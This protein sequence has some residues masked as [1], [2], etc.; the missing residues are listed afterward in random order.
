[1]DQ[2]FITRQFIVLA[3][4]LRKDVRKALSTLHNDFQQY[5]RAIRDAPKREQQD[6]KPEL[7]PLV[8]Q[9]ELHVPENIERDRQTHENRQHRLQIWVVIG[10]WA[11]FAA[12]SIY[13]GVAYLQWREMIGATDAA[14][15]A[16]D[17]SRRNRVQAERSLKATIDQFHLD[18]RA[19]LGVDS[20]S[21]LPK[22]N[23]DFVI[24]VVV[25]NTGKTPAMKVSFLI[26]YRAL[27]KS[28]RLAFKHGSV[29]AE[30]SNAMLPPNS[31]YHANPPIPADKVKQ[32]D[33]DLIKK[34]DVTIYVYADGTFEDV[35]S[36][37]HWI[38]FCYFLTTNGKNWV[39]CKSHNDTG[40]ID[41]ETCK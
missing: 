20:V 5:T 18:Q 41:T 14:G 24:D 29:H 12:A 15:R 8:V 9:A 40:N 10:T 26:T 17:E 11:A 30:Q 1:M 19:W 23:E 2:N 37:R 32:G 28:E 22:L 7:P 33:L 38:Q 16:V 21:G 4:K 3:K 34:G 27:K 13:A 25:K 35:F 6:Q 39:A 31:I 36:C